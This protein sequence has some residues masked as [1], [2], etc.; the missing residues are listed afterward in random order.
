[1]HADTLTR[2]LFTAQAMLMQYFGFTEA[3]ITVMIDTDKSK[4][5]PTG[6]NIKA[7]LK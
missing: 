4:T 5:Q 7:K 2:P 3:E 6:R 1:M